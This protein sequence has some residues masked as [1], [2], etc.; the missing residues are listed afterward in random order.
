MSKNRCHEINMFHANIPDMEIPPVEF[1][2]V[3]GI[4][5]ANHLGC[6]KTL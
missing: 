5:L 4:N 3:D 2:T 6:I 1:P